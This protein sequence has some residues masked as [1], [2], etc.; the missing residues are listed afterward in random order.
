MVEATEIVAL[1]LA[2]VCLLALVAMGVFVSQLKSRLDALLDERG[3]IKKSALPPDA[4]AGP[5]PS[6]PKAAGAAQEQLVEELKG[7][8]TAAEETIRKADAALQALAARVLTLEQPPPPPSKPLPSREPAALPLPSP[9]IQ[10]GEKQVWNKTE[11]QGG[12]PAPPPRDAAA[13]PPQDD[14]GT[15]DAAVRYLARQPLFTDSSF[16]QGLG[17]RISGLNPPCK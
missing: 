7:K 4:A 6:A 3:A 14:A 1:V 17:F 12:A 5:K 8:L 9:S 16:S 11:Q 15:R 10:G 13:P 2:S